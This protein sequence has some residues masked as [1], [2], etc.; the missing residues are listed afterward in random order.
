MNTI[1]G[2]DELTESFINTINGIFSERNNPLAHRGV[3]I[4]GSP[5]SGKTEFVIR[6]LKSH[7]FDVV[8]YDASDSRGKSTIETMTKQHM[9]EVNIMSMWNMKQKKIVIVM[10][11]IEAMN[12]GDKGGI[13]AL[14]KLLR[15]KKTKKQRTEA[16]NYSPIV[17]IGNRHMDK[18]IGDLMRVCA[19]YE[20]KT[21]TDAQI[22][23]IVKRVFKSPT[24]P[25]RTR[26]KLV[27]NVDGDLRKLVWLH[28]AIKKGLFLDAH[29]FDNILAPSSCNEDAKQVVRSIINQE[30]EFKQHNSMIGDA[31]RTIVG[32]L[33]HENVVDV[34]EK[35][36][37]RHALPIYLGILRRMCLGDFIDRNT[38]QKQVWQFNEMSSIIKTMISHHEFHEALLKLKSGSTNCDVGVYNPTEVRFTRVLT[39]YSSEFNN[40]SFVQSLCQKFG[41][42]KSD[43]EHMFLK[44]KE[45]YDGQS[46]EVVSLLASHDI[47]KQEVDRMFKM[48]AYDGARKVRRTSSRK[49]DTQDYE[50]S[51]ILNDVMMM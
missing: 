23:D 48:L 8:R 7:D 24:L 51:E 29:S 43:L 2:R 45:V 36:E 40:F 18:K 37:A 21:P 22:D 34:L 9:P 10:D 49:K 12:S 4:Y 31:D 50:E 16:H 1:L 11:E 33:W 15:P 6:T 13:N 17:C 44:F 41:I 3:Y 27:R 19:C 30:H 26:Q 25:V 28:D 42:D 32:L 39:K 20:V 35:L 38:F 46:S 5:G 47:V 14:T